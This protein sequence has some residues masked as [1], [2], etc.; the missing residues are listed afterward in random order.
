LNLAVGGYWP[1]YPDDTTVFPQQMRI[2]YVRVY[3]RKPESAAVAT[4]PVAPRPNP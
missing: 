4:K 2:D 3:S 1:G